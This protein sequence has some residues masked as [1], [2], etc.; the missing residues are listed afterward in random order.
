MIVKRIGFTSQRSQI[1]FNGILSIIFAIIA[2]KWT[3]GISPTTNPTTET[4][5]SPT[6]NTNP[7]LKEVLSRS[8][9]GHSQAPYQ[10]KN[11]GRALGHA[12]TNI[13]EK[14]TPKSMLSIVTK[15]KPRLRNSQSPAIDMNSM[16]PRTIPIGPGEKWHPTVAKI[17]VRAASQL[18][19]V[20]SDKAF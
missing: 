17:V 7:S 19:A 2:H 12:T 5:N 18:A 13:A 10:P 14:T 20:V 16:G 11:K 9:G 4:I 6:K 1:E 8:R 3:S 15:Q